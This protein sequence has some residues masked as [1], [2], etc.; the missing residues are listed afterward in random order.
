MV[1]L[2]I[3]EMAKI[4]QDVII[5]TSRC[6]CMYVCV[7]VCMYVC[8]CVCVCERVCMCM[9]VCVRACVRVCVSV[10]V[11]V[12]VCVCIVD[13]YVAEGRGDCNSDCSGVPGMGVV[14]SAPLLC[15]LTRCSLTKDMT[16]KEDAYKA[17]AI[18]ALCKITD[19]RC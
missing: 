15:S 14:R 19:V 6:V 5:V 13:I 18:R 9:Y 17:G 2:T 8:V 1:F 10:C 3:K 12:C 7:Y 4:A 16:G 11:C